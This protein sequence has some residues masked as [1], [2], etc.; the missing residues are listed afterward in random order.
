MTGRYWWQRRVNGQSA[1]R[2]SRRPGIYQVA[3]SNDQYDLI[4]W[5][6]FMHEECQWS[7]LEIFRI[8]EHF[9]EQQPGQTPL[10]SRTI[11]T[12]LLIRRRMCKK[13]LSWP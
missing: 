7:N 6:V 4:G 9:W 8:L 1:V 11:I 3:Y 5:A 2:R 10:T 13:G 12:W